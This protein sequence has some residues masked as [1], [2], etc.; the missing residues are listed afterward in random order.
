MNKFGYLRVSKDSSDVENQRR[1]IVDYL[2]GNADVKW[3]EDVISGRVDWQDR[4]LGKILEKAQAGDWLIV[5]ELPRL[6]RSTLNTLEVIDE[7]HKK[8]VLVHIARDRRVLDDSI[9]GK[10]FRTMAALFAEMERHYISERTKEGLRRVKASGKKLGRP[11]GELRKVKLDS[12]RKKIEELLS[13]KVSIASI[14][15]ILGC[16]RPTVYAYVKRRGL[17]LE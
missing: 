17:D 3:V 16:A 9:E 8:G 11:E 10:I 1:V 5:S 12:E 2:S 6:G 15:K 4:G 14:A 13:K 7:F